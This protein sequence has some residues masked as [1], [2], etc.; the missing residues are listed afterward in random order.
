MQIVIH[1][2]SDGVINSLPCLLIERQ[3]IVVNELIQKLNFQWGFLQTS[4]VS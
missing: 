1:S 2:N 3:G 4:I